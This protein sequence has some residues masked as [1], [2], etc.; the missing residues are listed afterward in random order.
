MK[1]E[2]WFFFFSFFFLFLL[3]AGYGWLQGIWQMVDISL[4]VSQ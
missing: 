4:P 1:A 3:I 2:A